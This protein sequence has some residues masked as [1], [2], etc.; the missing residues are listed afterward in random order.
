MYPYQH[1]KSLETYKETELPPQD[2]FYSDLT[3]ESISIEDYE[4]AKNVWRYFECEDLGDYTC[5]YLLTDVLLLADVYQKFRKSCLDHYGL[6]VAH[7]VS[8]P[9]FALEAALK[10]TKVKLELVQDPDMYLFM[11]MGIRGNLF[12]YSIFYNP[13]IKILPSLRWYFI[14]YAKT[15]QC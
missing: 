3:G 1:V 12:F 9:A 5:L 11:E 14:Y 8:A 4:H 13:E 7:F 2:A 10:M 15:R 6:D